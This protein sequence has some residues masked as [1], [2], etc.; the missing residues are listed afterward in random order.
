MVSVEGDK[1]QAEL[2]GRL[3]GGGEDKGE[4]ED[5]ETRFVLPPPGVANT[6]SYDGEE[7]RGVVL[8]RGFEIE[9]RSSKSKSA[10]S[11]SWDASAP[12]QLAYERNGSRIEITVVKRRSDP[13][14]G[15]GFGFDEL[16]RISSPAGGIFGDQK[17]TR[18]V[19][20][21]RKYRRA[22][23]DDGERRIEGL[24][25]RKTYRVLDGIAGLEMPTSTT[26]SQIVFTRDRKSV[27]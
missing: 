7:R 2:A 16:Y 20:V 13:P 5:F 25:I 6:Y 11:A 4:V 1:G 24:E 14:D 12:D 3:L 23:G 22:F 19:R 18:A 27:V 9:S 26:K 8:D 15:R 17:V 10:S 21:Q